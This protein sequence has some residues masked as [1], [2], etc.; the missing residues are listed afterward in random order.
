MSDI[1][2]ITV[3][4]DAERDVYK[5]NRPNWSGGE[6]VLWSAVKTMLASQAAEV[7]RLTKENDWLRAYTGQSA[8]ACVYCGLGADEMGKCERGFPGCA[9][10]DDQMLCREVGV[11]IERDALQAEVARLTDVLRRGGFVECDIPACNCGGWHHRYGLPERWAEI[12]QALIDAD[13]LGNST[14]NKPLNAIKRLADERDALLARVEAAEKNA[15]RMR[16]FLLAFINGGVNQDFRLWA[17]EVLSDM[18]GGK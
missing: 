7:A 14:G 6:V 10:A 9:R 13:V 15:G 3:R 4:W 1:D 11:A 2:I 17:S 16:E 18:E 8:K 12:T 5:V